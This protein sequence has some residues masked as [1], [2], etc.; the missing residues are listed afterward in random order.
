MGEKSNSISSEATL[1]EVL[2]GWNG[3]PHREPDYTM[4]AWFIDPYWYIV[5]T[6]GIHRV[7]ANNEH[8]TYEDLIWAVGEQMRILTLDQYRK[9]IDP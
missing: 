6:D 1:K 3:E 4:K 7:I 5:T 8:M 9:S 2:G